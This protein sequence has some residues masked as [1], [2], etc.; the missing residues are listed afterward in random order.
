MNTSPLHIF[1]QGATIGA[2][3]RTV[4]LAR[5]SESGGSR[6]SSIPGP[7]IED[8]VGPRHPGLVRDYLRNVGGASTWYKGT[9]PPHMF[10]QWGLPIMSRTLDDLPYDINRVINA[11]CRLDVHGP[12]PAD[13][14]L[15]LGARLIDLDDNGRRALVKQQL[16][17]GTASSPGA[18]ES[19]VTV[20][21]PLKKKA[22]SREKK[23]K[24]RVPLNAR[25]IDRWRL[26]SDSG[27]DFA[28]LT[29][30]FNPI[31]WIP[32][33]AR[34]AG[35]KNTILH[36][37]STM[38][39]MIESMNRHVFSSDPDRLKSIEVRFSAPL[40]LPADVGVYIHCQ[41]GCFVGSAPGA[42]AC[43]SG[44]FESRR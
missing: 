16:V 38:A 36:G 25:E 11:G 37:F 17:T 31:H 29:G 40:V 5:L 8:T 41:G 9:V 2:L 7:I 42:P 20:L 26:P 15:K 28:F 43:L 1:R 19:T 4:A 32:V 10:P 27:L 35:F 13:E 6:P 24:I 12:I 39:R 44:R 21:F 3:I 33:A 22:G 18:L 23:D 34:A 14:P 30:D